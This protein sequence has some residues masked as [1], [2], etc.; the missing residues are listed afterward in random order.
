MAESIGL[1]NHLPNDVRHT[2]Q[3][4]FV[5]RNK[6][7]HWGFEWPAQ[8]RENFQKQLTQW[9]PEWFTLSTKDDKPGIFYMTDAFIEHCFTTIYCVISGV[10]AFARAKS[11]R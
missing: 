11:T 6:M 9:P 8:Q 3:A 4:L 10:G 7:F 2:L 5:Y 1:D